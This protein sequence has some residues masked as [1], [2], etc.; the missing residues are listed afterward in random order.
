MNVFASPKNIFLTG[1]IAM[2]S[3]SALVGIGIFIRGEFG[4]IEGKILATTAAIG[5]FSLAALCGSFLNERNRVSSMGNITMAI[6][7]VTLIY[8]LFLIW[9]GIEPGEYTMRAWGVLFVLTFSL[10]HASLILLVR[11]THTLV[12]SV[13]YATLAFIALV[14]LILITLILDLQAVTDNEVL[15][16]TLGVF[17]ILDGLGTIVM[18]LLY[19]IYG[20]A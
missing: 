11:P 16:R 20:R 3:L 19:V 4:V 10:A 1:V 2:L 12:R 6:A 8:T 7:M 5:G 17:A 18:P 13:R 15:M 9:E 14:T